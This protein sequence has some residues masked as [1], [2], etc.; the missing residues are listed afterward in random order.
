[1][2][3][4]VEGQEE[5][6]ASITKA[7]DRITVLYQSQGF[8]LARAVVPSQTMVAGVL[9]VQVIEAH[10]DAVVLNNQTQLSD[11]FLH[12]V[13]EPLTSGQ[14]IEQAPL[15]QALLLLSDIPGVVVNATLKPGVRL[16]ATDLEITTTT[17]SKG[18]SGN[19][20][21]DNYGN[22]YVG[23]TR[24][25]Q[26]LR[27]KNF[28]NQQ[29]GTVLDI[30]GLTSGGGLNYGRVA[31]ETVLSGAVMRVGGAYSALQYNCMTHHDIQTEPK[32]AS[33]NNHYRLHSIHRRN[34]T[35]KIVLISQR[36]SFHLVQL[37]DYSEDPR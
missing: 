24:V 6:L 11:V 15:D 3:Q 12:S 22:A 37:Q 18:L 33:T 31:Y 19:S 16:G 21:I 36:I 2:V 17:P 34:K 9:L 35:E 32:E 14:V 23:R 1:L 4:D 5:T 25:G 26:S 8:P 29:T 20:V 27:M 30:N 7:V 10:Y 28:L 13:L